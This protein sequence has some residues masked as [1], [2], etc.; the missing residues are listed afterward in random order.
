[1]R[2]G[3]YRPVAL[4]KLRAGLDAQGNWTAWHVRQADQSI[5]A[6]VRPTDIKNGVDPINTRCFVDAPYAVPNFTNEY[7]M[8]NTHVPPGFWRAVAHTNNPFFRECFI[9]ELAHAAGKDPYQ[10]R[11]PLLQGKRD[12]RGARRGRQGRRLGQPPA[13]GRLPRHRSC[14]FLRQLHRGGGGVVGE[15]RHGAGRDTSDRGHRLR[16]RRP[17]RRGESAG[18]KAA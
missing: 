7:A 5:I 3:R 16:V 15:G 1:M 9:D 6:T 2:Q 17:P 13:E 4:V 14:G 8:R 18:A 12:L 10:F 11:R